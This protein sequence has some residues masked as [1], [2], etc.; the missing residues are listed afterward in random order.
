MNLPAPDAPFIK[1]ADLH[2]YL[3]GELAAD[4]VPSVEA[5]LTADVEARILLKSLTIQR[6]AL[7]SKYP[8]PDT[9][10]KTKAMMDAV[11]GQ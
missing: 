6:Q 1:D 5:R 9:C 3:D 7:Q 11:L 10:P 2:A 4:A 8:L